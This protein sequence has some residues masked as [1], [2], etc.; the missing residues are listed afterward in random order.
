MLVSVT[1]RTREIGIRKAIG[2]VRRDIVTQF[3][4]EAMTLSAIGGAIGVGIGLAIALVVRNVSPLAACDAAMVD[5]RR[6]DGIDLDRTVLRIYRDEAASLI[7]STRCVTSR[8]KFTAERAEIT[9][10]KARRL[11]ERCGDSIVVSRLTTQLS[12]RK[13]V[14]ASRSR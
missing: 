7:R 1:E 8:A 4:I 6:P 5:R 11:C 2:A 12:P 3:L 9:E 14:K 13:P 10:K